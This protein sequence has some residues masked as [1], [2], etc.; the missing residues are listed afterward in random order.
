M[1]YRWMAAGLL[2]VV[3][4]QRKRQRLPVGWEAYDI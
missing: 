3:E 4:I 2:S 1:V